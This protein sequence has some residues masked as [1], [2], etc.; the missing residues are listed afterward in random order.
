M[1]LYADPITVNCRKVIAGLDLLGV[2]YEHIHVDYFAGE[3]K[4][5]EYLE[6]NPNAAL[7]ALV[8]DDF[9]LSESNAILQY[10]AELKGAE[11]HYPREPRVRA[12]INRWLLWEAATWFPSCYTFLVENVVKPLLQAEPD[13]AVLDRETPNWHRLANILDKRLENQK[14][15]CGD[16][17]T[18]ADIAVAAPMH[19]HPWQK[20]PLDAHPN[21]KRWIKDVEQLPCWK[22]SDPV[23]I[24]GLKAA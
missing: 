23:P 22:N 2:R 17:V 11:Q 6:I 9:K 13:Q 21:L 20:L 7:P 10:A 24:L 12:D 3:Q 16:G 15:L 8:D 18:L 19:L 4:K 5:P 14:W 1:K